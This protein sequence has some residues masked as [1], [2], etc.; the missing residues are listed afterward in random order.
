[1]TAKR[2]RVNR[3]LINIVVFTL[4]SMLFTSFAIGQDNGFQ[5]S[6][7]K[8]TS[9]SDNGFQNKWGDAKKD[10]LSSDSTS[11]VFGSYNF[12]DDKDI[13]YRAKRQIHKG[14]LYF[15]LG[16]GKYDKALEHYKNAYRI[17]PN[18]AYLDFK[19]GQ[20]YLLMRKSK[21][22]SILYLEKAYHQNKRVSKEI[23]YYLGRAH[24]VN[25]D[26]VGAIEHYEKSKSEYRRAHSKDHISLAEKHAHNALIEK[27]INECKYAMLLKDEPQKVLIETIGDSINTEYSEYDPFITANESMLLFT[28]R[29]KGTRGN[30]KAEIDHVYYEDIYVSYN[31]YGLWTKAKPMK[32]RFNK[33]T[34]DA[35]IGLSHDGKEMFIYRDTKQGDI[36]MSELNEDG[37]WK[38][39]KPLNE[40]NTGYHESSACFS[41]DKSMIYF[42]SN[43]PGGYGGSDIYTSSKQQDG[44]WGEPQN[45]GRK[46]NTMYDE[47]RVF[48]HPNGKVLFFCSKGHN[49]MGGYDIFFSQMDDDGKW[50]TPENMGYPINGPDDEISFVVNAEGDRGYF[51]SYRP[52]GT[53]DR[54]IYVVR[55]GLSAKIGTLNR[56]D[57]ILSKKKVLNKKEFVAELIKIG[58]DSM[59]VADVLPVLPD[60]TMDHLEDM[61]DQWDSEIAD[62]LSLLDSTSSKKEIVNLE[63]QIKVKREELNLLNSAANPDEF[64]TL[65]QQI[66][67]REDQ[68]SLL[69]NTI[70]LY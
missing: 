67:V 19:I 42:V 40:I 30:G 26:Y 27:Q 20:T 25:N 5:S 47:E 46:I 10:S 43:K 28:S 60:E 33:L 41:F 15:N 36:Y 4:I 69:G 59:L 49:S 64:E 63:Q 14:D 70:R 13:P 45:I 53:G 34:N 55:F 6:N 9:K 7:V 56:E 51:S 50:G 31:E 18:I 38:S 52:G 11:H 2:I 54:D 62:L 65:Q 24:Q 3:G 12:R 66:A 16:P 8:K 32:N 29:R 48:I 22:K 58:L 57:E 37:D 61:I 23:H 21:F 1:M 39:P 35:I 68:I 17:D 44:T